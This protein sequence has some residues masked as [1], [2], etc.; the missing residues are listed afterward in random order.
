[1]RRWISRHSGVEEA[2]LQRTRS[3]TEY[4]I[5]NNGLY[6]V[7]E[8]KNR[9]EGVRINITPINCYLEISHKYKFII[10]SKRYSQSQ[11]IDYI[12]DR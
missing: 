2:E 4:C 6:N 1:M 5:G 9:C 12:T 3:R 7:L 11:T 8:R 10:N